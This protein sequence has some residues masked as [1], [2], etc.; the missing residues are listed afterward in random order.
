MSTDTDC[1]VLGAL[2]PVHSRL[3]TL[4]CCSARLGPGAG[5]ARP[6]PW[7]AK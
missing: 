5:K 2:S 4:G 3:H 6:G 7:P 1:S